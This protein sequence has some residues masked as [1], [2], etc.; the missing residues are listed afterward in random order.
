MGGPTPVLFAA[1]LLVALG[2]AISIWAPAIQ[3]VARRAVE[4]SW[5]AR[6]APHV[7][8]Y[9]GSRENLVMI[10]LV[11]AGAIAAGLAVAVM[12]AVDRL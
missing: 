3:A 10:R 4:Q 12:V 11:G 2:I 5:L 7:V 1:C 8:E 9:V 6:V